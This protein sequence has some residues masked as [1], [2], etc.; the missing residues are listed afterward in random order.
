MKEE[1]RQKAD[2]ED[3]ADEESTP[4]PSSAAAAKVIEKLL[5]YATGRGDMGI[6]NAYED[7]YYV[8]WLSLCNSDAL[9]EMEGH[10]LVPGHLGQISEVSW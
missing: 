4:N 2:S 5:L 3:E 9:Y 7:S 10:S 6:L 1:D 8:E